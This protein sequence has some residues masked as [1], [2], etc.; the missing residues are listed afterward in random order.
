MAPNGS[1]FA[2]SKNGSVYNV[3]G[4]LSAVNW[5]H[6]HTGKAVNNTYN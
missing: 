5:E 2:G 3:K 6:V 4:D 1:I